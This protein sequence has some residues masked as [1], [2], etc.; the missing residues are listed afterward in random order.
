MRPTAIVPRPMAAIHAWWSR[1]GPLLP[2][3][4]RRYVALPLLEHRSRWRVVRTPKSQATRIR[5]MP[6]DAAGLPVGGRLRP[7]T[8]LP[9]PHDCDSCM[10]VVAGAAPTRQGGRRSMAAGY[11]RR[12]L[13]HAP[14]LARGAFRCFDAV[15]AAATPGHADP[16]LG[17]DHEHTTCETSRAC[18]TASRPVFTGKPGLSRDVHHPGTRGL[19]CG[20]R[21]GKRRGPVIP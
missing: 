20:C 14:T 4:C 16:S 19:L 9:P 10:A 1:L 8:I 18:G 12:I 17:H 2:G 21:R 7:T 13:L 3:A 15:V 5:E 6:G 11:G